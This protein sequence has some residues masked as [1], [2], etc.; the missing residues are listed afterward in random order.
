M[1]INQSQPGIMPYEPKTSKSPILFIIIGVVVI[2]LIGVGVFLLMKSSG[3]NLSDTDLTSGTSVG[4]KENDEV[5]FNIDDEEH[6]ITVLSV[7]EEGVKISIQSTPINVTLTVGQTK[8]YDFENDGTYDISIKLNNVTDG[9]ADLYIKKI[10]ETACEEDWSCTDWGVCA[11]GIQNRTCT[12]ANSCG[13]VTQKP[14]DVQE[15]EEVVVPACAEQSGTLCAASQTCNGTMVN[16]SEGS[17][18]CVG[19]C[20]TPSATTSSCGTDFACLI[21]ASNTCS[22]ANMTYSNFGTSNITWVQNYTYYYKIR[23]FEGENCEFYQEIMEISGSYTAAGVSALTSQGKTAEEIEAMEAEMNDALQTVEG[24]T[25]I[26]RF[27][28]YGLNEYLTQIRDE[29]YVLTEEEATEHGC[30]GALYGN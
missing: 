6:K 24:D 28:V 27:S 12:E 16:A 4:L 15:C 2:A 20:I 1:D 5:K 3:G 7:I 23:G 8:K 30:T 9:K 10:N 22:I 25:G 11:S 26:C 29:N 21:T 17:N 13:T 19:S 18:C 14:K